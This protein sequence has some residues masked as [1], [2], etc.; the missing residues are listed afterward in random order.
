MRF[1]TYT[2]GQEQRLGVVV[3]KEVIDLNQAQPQISADLRTALR[4]GQDLTGVRAL[5]RA[6][7]DGWS[8]AEAVAW[9]LSSVRA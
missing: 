8:A 1:T 2:Q 3:G 7:T 9:L 6:L 5:L 4:L